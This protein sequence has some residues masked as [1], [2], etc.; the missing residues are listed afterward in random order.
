MNVFLAGIIQ[1][2]LTEPTIHDQDWRQP[3]REVLRRHLPDADVYCHYSRHPDSIGYELPEIRRTLAE[4]L[5][6]AAGCDLLI[7]YATSASMGT[8]L[9]MYR[10]AGA[11]AAVVAISPMAANWVLRA[12]SDAILPH[13]GAFERWCRDGELHKLLQAKAAS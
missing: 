8:A 11:R 2:S 3:V 4:G 6:R 5:E 9:E 10:A 13:L 12:Y 1:G 7:A